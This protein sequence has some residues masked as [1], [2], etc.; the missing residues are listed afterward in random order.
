MSFESRSDGSR[1]R[2]DDATKN[3]LQPL[4]AGDDVRG[5]V[6]EREDHRGGA[7]DDRDTQ[8]RAVQVA[9]IKFLLKPPGT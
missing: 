6:L 2:V 3:I 7:A 5:D 1:I 9:P 4:E 8:G